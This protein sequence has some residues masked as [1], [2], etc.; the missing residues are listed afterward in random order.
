MPH[1]ID[2]KQ[3][4]IHDTPAYRPP[5]P[6]PPGSNDLSSRIAR[7]ET[8]QFHLTDNTHRI[9]TESLTR[10]KDLLES[11]RLL[12]KRVA[13]VERHVGTITAVVTWLPKILKYAGGVVL[14]AF[15]VMGKMTPDGAKLFLQALGFP[16]G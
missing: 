13:S 15:L 2:P 9:E 16:T 3:R 1:W 4:G 10:G 6:Q 7:L 11:V 12:D 5:Y 14:F 8:H